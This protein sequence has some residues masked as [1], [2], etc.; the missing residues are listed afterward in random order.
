MKRAKA[1]GLRMVGCAVRARV[2]AGGANRS[3]FEGLFGL[4]AR[5]AAEK[6]DAD[7]V[8]TP[9]GATLLPRSVDWSAL[10]DCI[11]LHPANAA[12]LFELVKN[13]GLGATT[14]TVSGSKP[15]RRKQTYAVATALWG[16]GEAC[17]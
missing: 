2:R 10:H 9:R 1:K 7:G 6:L 16:M 15:C 11:R 13:E 14:I 12:A 17:L 3:V 4:S 8:P 5:K